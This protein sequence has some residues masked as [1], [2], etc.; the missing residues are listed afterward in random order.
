MT[1]SPGPRDR[2]SHDS[3]LASRAASHGGQGCGIPSG[4][5]LCRMRS[6]RLCTVVLLSTL[7]IIKQVVPTTIGYVAGAGQNME[8]SPIG[9]AVLGRCPHVVVEVR[10]ANLT[11]ILDT[12]SQVT[13]MRSS[14]G[15]SVFGLPPSC[16]CAG[17]IALGILRGLLPSEC[18]YPQ[19]QRFSASH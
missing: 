18:G 8:K 3:C 4:H 10:G 1:P 2:F 12:G 9:S 17:R 5:H 16:W 14:Q 15:V 13:L 11:C 6:G 19:R 7:G